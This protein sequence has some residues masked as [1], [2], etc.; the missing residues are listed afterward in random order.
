MKI[1]CCLYKVP[2]PDI[3]CFSIFSFVISSSKVY[4]FKIF[5]LKRYFKLC[6][7]LTMGTVMQYKFDKQAVNCQFFHTGAVVTLPHL[8]CF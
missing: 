1:Q 5:L 7:L 2:V 3:K 8:F 4:F 6:K